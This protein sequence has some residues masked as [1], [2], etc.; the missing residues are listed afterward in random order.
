MK[1]KVIEQ[2]WADCQ[3]C[4]LSSVRTSIGFGKGN[5][6]ARVVVIGETPMVNDEVDEMFGKILAAAGIPRSDIWETNVC[7]CRPKENDQG[8]VRAPN[9]K[10]IQACKPRLAEEL[11]LLSSA[12][13]IILAGNVPLYAASGQ[14]G[15]TKHRGWLVPMPKE[16]ESHSP[17]GIYATLHTASLLKG[18][19]EQIQQKKK[20]VWEDWQAIAQAYGELE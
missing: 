13:I 3:G 15:I 12:R 2:K 8:R 7:L 5:P 16:H 4:A 10:E 9:K 19:I 6:D 17:H 14:R 20:W 18:S 11:R 1:L